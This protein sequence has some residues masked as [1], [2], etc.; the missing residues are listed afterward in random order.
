MMIGLGIV[1]FGM[2]G[3]AYA[4][5]AESQGFNVAAV[6]SRSAPQGSRFSVYDDMS[7][8]L[9]DPSIDSVV[10]CSP[11]WS[12]AEHAIASLERGKHVM[13]EKPLGIN[14]AQIDSLRKAALESRS[15]VVGL[16]MAETRQ[17]DHV[18]DL[19]LA[20]EIGPITLIESSID[21]PGPP[22][23]N[24]YYS[25][26]AGG[27]ASMDTLPYALS[28]ALS[29]CGHPPESIHGCYSQVIRRRRCGD[30]LSVDQ[31]V[32]DTAVLSMVM[33]YGQ[34]VLVRS[35]WCVSGANDVLNLYGRNGTLELDCWSGRLSIV[36]GNGSR[37][38]ITEDHPSSVYAEAAKLKF[39][40]SR[41]RS[42]S[43]SLQNALLTM[44]LIC[45]V[46][47]FEKRVGK[48]GPKVASNIQ[49]SRSILKLP[50]GYW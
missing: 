2:M 19:V 14:S 45:Q 26:A 25:A 39:F 42:G 16:P 47:T 36:R 8:F 10:V 17:L 32:D 34:Q 7:E 3:Q 38:I 22:R 6:L 18:R 9:E 28:R 44:D 40:E 33:P 1:G 23:A 43:S 5:A 49:D 4:R 35:S 50:D 37:A 15:V 41:I 46:S 29:L 13:V 11:H 27:G 31:E 24:W 48:Y 21:V 30:G 20:D 12:H